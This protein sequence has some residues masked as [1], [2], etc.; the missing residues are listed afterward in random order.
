MISLKEIA[1]RRSLLS[2]MFACAVGLAASID[3]SAGAQVPQ[4]AVEPDPSAGLITRRSNH[5]VTETIQRFEAAVRDKGDKGWVVFTEIDHAAAAQRAGQRLRPRTV[6]VFGNPRI[7][8]AP[9]QRAPTLAIDVPLRVLVW[10]DDAG[11]VWLTYTSSDYM[12][13]TVYPRHGLFMSSE[14]SGGVKRFLH[15]VAGQATD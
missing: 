7:G 11:A 3:A 8:T 9:M 14:V 12:A 1:M 13:R 10:E 6:I 2:G 4:Q 15:E 5:T